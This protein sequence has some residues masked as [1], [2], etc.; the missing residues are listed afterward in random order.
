MLPYVRIQFA[1]LY[2]RQLLIRQRNCVPKVIDSE[3]IALNI[4]EK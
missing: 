2:Y 1:S 3:I 4:G